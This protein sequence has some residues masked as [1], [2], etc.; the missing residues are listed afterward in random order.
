MDYSHLSEYLRTL[1]R[2]VG[3]ETLS[4]QGRLRKFRDACRRARPDLAAEWTRMDKTW[5]WEKALDACKT[6]IKEPPSPPGPPRGSPNLWTRLDGASR[7]DAPPVLSADGDG[8]AVSGLH[9]NHSALGAGRGNGAR[10]GSPRVW[11]R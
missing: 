7:E 3:W 9:G 2:S 4:P 11:K 1:A 6:A 8:Q 10:H 5:E